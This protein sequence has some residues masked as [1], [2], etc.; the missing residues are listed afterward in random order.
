MTRNNIASSERIF[1]CDL[2]DMELIVQLMEDAP[3]VAVDVLKAKVDLESDASATAR[4]KEFHDAIR[5]H[6]EPVPSRFV[7]GHIDHYSDYIFPDGQRD[8]AET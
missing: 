4:G 7:H 1:F 8:A 3:D 2:E 5:R 6:A